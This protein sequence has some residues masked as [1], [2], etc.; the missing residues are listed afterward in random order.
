MKDMTV[1]EK[2][3]G[4]SRFP[5]LKFVCLTEESRSCMK[6][7]VLTLDLAKQTCFVSVQKNMQS[8]SDLW[9]N[10]VAYH[11]KIPAHMCATT[12]DQRATRSMRENWMGNTRSLHSTG[13]FF[14]HLVQF[15]QRLAYT[16]PILRILKHQDRYQPCSKT[17]RFLYSL[18]LHCLVSKIENVS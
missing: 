15:S 4:S 18:V 1:N 17:R 16:E 13:L 12:K 14:V 8:L 10:G 11:Q 2:Y 6:T 5:S 7:A 9:Q 3:E